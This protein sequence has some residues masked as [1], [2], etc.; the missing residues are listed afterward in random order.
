[1]LNCFTCFS[2]KNISNN[3]FRTLSLKQSFSV[4]LGKNIV[5]TMHCFKKCLT[6]AL[7]LVFKI[8]LTMAFKKVLHN[9]IFMVFSA[10]GLLK[11]CIGLKMLNC[12]TS[13]SVQNISIKAVLILSL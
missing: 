6:V 7:I 3:G 4:V 10:K 5:K 11:F 2:V 13:F 9:N 12:Y 8:Y 1:M